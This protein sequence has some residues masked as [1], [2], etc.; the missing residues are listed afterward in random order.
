MAAFFS[1]VLFKPR[2]ITEVK[3][4]HS[5]LFLASFSVIARLSKELNFFASQ[6]RVKLRERTLAEEVA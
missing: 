1:T 4:V 6:F 5:L 3:V 2:F